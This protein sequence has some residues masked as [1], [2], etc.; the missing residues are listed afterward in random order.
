MSRSLPL[1]WIASVTWSSISSAGSCSGHAASATRPCWPSAAQHSSARC[2][3]IGAV[4][5][6]RA[7][8]ALERLALQAAT[9]GLWIEIE[10][11]DSGEALDQLLAY[12]NHEAAAGRMPTIVA[13]P[14]TMIDPVTARLD[15]NHTQLLIDP[16][17][18]ERATA[19]AL[20]RATITTPAALHDIAHE[21]ASRRLKQ[22]SDEVGRIAATLARL[23]KLFLSLA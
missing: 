16:D 7:S 6:T 11:G 13:A 3:A 14:S 20:V 18:I 22:L 21:P 15:A 23:E 1:I 17:P 2:G 4:S 10:T 19:L 5:F 12:A 8:T 9:S